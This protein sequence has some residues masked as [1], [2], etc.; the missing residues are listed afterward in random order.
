MIFNCEKFSE[1]YEEAIELASMNDDETGPFK[2][3]KINLKKDQYIQAQD[4]GI[5]HGF[6]ARDKDGSLVGYSVYYVH[7]HGLYDIV[8][9]TQDLL[10]MHPKHRGISA[11]KFIKF[12]DEYLGEIGVDAICKMMSSRHDYSKTLTGLGYSHT[13]SVYMKPIKK[14]LD[15]WQ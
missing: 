9:A 11:V 14:G 2:N 4:A 3:L 7:S 15:L 5:M 8:I 10:F 6:T 12:I 1:V 13:E